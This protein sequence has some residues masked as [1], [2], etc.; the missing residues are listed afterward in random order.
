MDLV[1]PFGA[2]SVGPIEL[3]LFASKDSV[4]LT[5]QSTLSFIRLTF[6]ET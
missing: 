6:F 2:K 1:H 3:F 4:M 5:R